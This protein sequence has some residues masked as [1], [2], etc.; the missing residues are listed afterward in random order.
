MADEERPVSG[1][2]VPEAPPGPRLSVGSV[3]RRTFEIFGREWSLFL[4]LSLPAAA[5]GGL[6]LLVPADD[7]ALSLL[8]LVPTLVISVFANAVLTVATAEIAADRPVVV[9]D[10]VARGQRAFPRLLV[11]L[12]ISALAGIAVGFAVV[13]TL[14]TATTAWSV[15]LF[16]IVLLVLA[17]LV[18]FVAVRIYPVFALATLERTGPVESLRRTWSLTRGRALALFGIAL[19]MG[20]A[21]GPAYWGASLLSLEPGVPAVLANALALLVTAPVLTISGVLAYLDLRAGS[22]PSEG[23]AGAG[24]GSEPPVRSRRGP[25]AIGLAI[26]LGVG[27]LLS[28]TGVGVVGDRLDALLVPGSNP[29]VIVT[30]RTAGGDNPCLPGDPTAAFLAGEEVWFGGYLAE[31]VL[32]GVEAEVEVRR[33]GAAVS[34]GTQSSGS[35]LPLVCLPIGALDDDLPAGSYEIVVRLEGRIIGSG[36]FAIAE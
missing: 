3:V 21:T 11:L 22:A 10:V 18:I 14:L 9:A 33:D 2:I 25:R 32:S 6:S 13:V 34:T 36:T 28:V 29:G 7:V 4:A 30:G 15:G 12:V 5:A 27:V 35:F 17:A 31:P 20:L 8:V 1:W 19:V 16:A 23:R 26:V 24:A